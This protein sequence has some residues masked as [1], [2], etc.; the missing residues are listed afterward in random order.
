MLHTLI[1]KGEFDSIVRDKGSDQS[2]MYQAALDDLSDGRD[3][4]I[5]SKSNAVVSAS[6]EWALRQRILD[7]SI[8]N[9]Y[10]CLA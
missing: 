4:M 8:I 5:H 3:A 6:N 7:M 1:V 9:K 2:G 10:K